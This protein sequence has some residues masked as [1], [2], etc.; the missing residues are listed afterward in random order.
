MPPPLWEDAPAAFAVIRE[1]C[2]ALNSVVVPDAVWPD[3]LKATQGPVDEAF[4][5]PIMYG[6]YLDGCLCK[7]TGPIHRYLLDPRYMARVA[8]GY[9]TCLRE[10]WFLE[11]DHLSRHQEARRYM[12][13][14][15]ELMLA[16]HLEESGWSI[17]GMEA[18]GDEADIIAH[19]ALG[20][21]HCI[22]VKY[23]GRYDDLHNS[24]VRSVQGGADVIAVSPYAG[25]NYVM[26]RVYVAARQLADKRGRKVACVVIDR[27]AWNTL[28]ISLGGEGW[29]NWKAPKLFDVADESWL[30]IQE[31][32]SKTS[33]GFP[34]D[35]GSRVAELDEVQLYVQDW[36][37]LVLKRAI[38][39]DGSAE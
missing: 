27:F 33:P 11:T 32:M 7:F 38:A 31:S 8:S 16:D 30:R 12:G 29:I 4:H 35:L 19:D 13:K 22:E 18:W 37:D 28:Q 24:I 17:D 25:A 23:I 20:I 1:Q 10:R 5:Q 21:L 34:G 2:S 26:S 3:Y 6:A 9:G 39:L 15:E 36:P 14:Y